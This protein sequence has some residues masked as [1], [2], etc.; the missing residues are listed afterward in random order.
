[1]SCDYA[2][3]QPATCRRRPV[4]TKAA[5]IERMS[6]VS[7]PGCH[8]VVLRRG[9]SGKAKMETRRCARQV[10][11]R[12]R[13]PAW[14]DPCV[15][16]V[17]AAPARRG[18]AASAMSCIRVAIRRSGSRCRDRSRCR[19]K[20]GRGAHDASAHS[21]SVCLFVVG[22]EGRSHPAHRRA[23]RPRKAR[24]RLERGFLLLW[25]DP[26]AITTHTGIFQRGRHPRR[27]RLYIAQGVPFLGAAFPLND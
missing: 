24:L 14:S 19:R 21:E 27:R 4:C 2:C 1:M 15:C 5:L 13:E 20:D 16:H 9:A 25:P 22:T 17:A 12:V 10:V 11:G 7:P 3:L 8:G 23:R 26:G 18:P 6:L